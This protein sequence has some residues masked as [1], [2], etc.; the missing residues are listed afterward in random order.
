MGTPE[1]AVSDAFYSAGI[2]VPHIR[3]RNSEFWDDLFLLILI[4]FTQAET[5]SRNR[6]EPY[7]EESNET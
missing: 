2:V 4:D 7:K 1:Q 5:A 6:D 3:N